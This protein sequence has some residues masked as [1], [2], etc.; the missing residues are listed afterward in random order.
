MR[1]Y[2]RLDRIPM[3]HT[4]GVTAAGSLQ[5][6]VMFILSLKQRRQNID[7]KPLLKPCLKI[8]TFFY[9]V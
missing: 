6:D 1:P 8:A 5:A 4:L 2:S 7:G 3:G 9:T